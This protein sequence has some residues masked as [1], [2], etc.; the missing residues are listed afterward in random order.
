MDFENDPYL[1]LD[2]RREGMTSETGGADYVGLELNEPKV[3]TLVNRLAA[4]NV[5]SDAEDLLGV[6][7]E[8]QFT[9]HDL[10]F[11]G[12]DPMSPYPDDM[13]S[14]DLEEARR[15]I[16]ET[17]AGTVDDEGLAFNPDQT[18]GS[19]VHAGYAAVLDGRPDA[20]DGLEQRMETRKL[21][22]SYGENLS[23]SGVP[24]HAN[25]TT[26]T[27]TVYEDQLRTLLDETHGIE[28]DEAVESAQSELIT[29]VQS[30][31]PESS[32]SPGM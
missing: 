22:V 29:E 12:H 20:M 6:N 24:K 21:E 23:I 28:L 8:L 13:T 26:F 11:F 27:P 2:L 14:D 32:V 10:E 7:S 1:I 30:D 18:V 5:L 31:V 15:T 16:L 9:D 4:G 17:P 3:Q 19:I 25:F